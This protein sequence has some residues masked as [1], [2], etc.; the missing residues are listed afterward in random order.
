MDITIDCKAVE[1]IAI[2]DKALKVRL[3]Q[4]REYA[5]Q[6]LI[7]DIAT[8]YGADYI[9]DALGSNWKEALQAALNESKG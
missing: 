1:S 8:Q 3:N 2:T 7:L 4:V 5:L 9:I 6:A